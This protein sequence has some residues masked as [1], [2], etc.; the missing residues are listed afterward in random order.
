MNK[1]SILLRLKNR[2]KLEFKND[3]LYLKFK[4]FVLFE[5]EEASFKK[6]DSDNLLILKSKDTHFEYWLDQD[7]LI[8]PWQTHW[9]QLKNSFLLKLK[10]NILKSLIKKGV[11]K[12][13]N[14]N[15]LC[16][17]LS[18]STPAFYNLYKNNIEMISVLKLKR[19]LNYLDAS[20]MDFNNKIE[21]TKKG[22]RISINNLKFPI[23]LNSKYGA[24]LLGYIVSDGCIY[25][26]KKG[27]NVIRTKYSTNE[28][29]SIDSFTNCISKIYGK[30]HFNQET[31]RNC[32]ILRIG[33]SIIGNSLLKAGAIMGHKAKNDGEVPWLIRF[34]QNL[35]EHYLRATFSDE[36][37]VYMG[38]I[39]YI[40]ISRHKHIRDLNK[41]QLEILKKLRIK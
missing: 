26:D 19:L 32:T 12:A 16:R 1:K 9:F 10:E 28:E 41:R 4:D 34:N 27:R 35:R 7:I 18:M 6:I 3:K 2:N 11:T 15:K 24:L 30:V 40:V 29:E 20:Y 17:S 13:G 33:S 22:S 31:I 25:I 21:Y 23:D 39:N 36:A 14:L 8:P 5:I 37:S 38:K